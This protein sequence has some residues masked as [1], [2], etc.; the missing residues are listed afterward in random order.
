MK[1]ITC[2]ILLLTILIPNIYFYS[3]TTITS[4]TPNSICD[5]LPNQK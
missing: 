1:K 3:E 5:Q 2:Y 4:Q